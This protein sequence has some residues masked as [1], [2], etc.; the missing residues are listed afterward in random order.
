M[1]AL[2]L[3]GGK[4][5]RLQPLTNNLPKP[6]VP[7]MNKPL[8]ERTMFNLK[9]CGIT[10]IVISSC[11]KPHYM[12]NY[13][14]TGE[15]FGLAIEY[16]V[17]DFPLGTG[18]AIKKAG[19]KF[20]EPFVVFNSDI[21]SDINIKE[22]LDLHKSS[23]ALATIAVTEVENPSAYG[24]I[25]YDKN[26]YALS[27]TEKPDPENITS[28]FINAGIYIFQPEVLL[29]I[30]GEGMVSVER[31]TFP[32]LLAK[33]CRISVYKSSCYWMDIGTVEKY[34]QA[35]ADIMKGKCNLVECK[36]TN[37]DIHIGENSHI[38][39]DCK[40]DG[41]VYMGDDVTIAERTYISNSVIGNNVSIGAASTIIGSIIWNGI[42][43]GS[44]KN[45][46]NTVV[47]ENPEFYKA[48]NVLSFPKSSSAYNLHLGL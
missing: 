8:I 23:K 43:I 26:G 28:R 41:P 12:K 19:S 37:K 4:G 35:H 14:G 6:M 21:L 24:V 29:E 47:T 42:D 38:H 27:F 1:K 48:A 7:I 2:F 44:K 15:K 18:G 11:Y 33:G 20:K 16:V 25:E 40:M 22:M 31:Q 30:P 46:L 17:E 39:P 3:A 9:K 13:F 32:M 34:M 36:F 45:I 5:L 10:E